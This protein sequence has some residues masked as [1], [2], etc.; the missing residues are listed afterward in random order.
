MPK[1]KENL[2][3]ES[4]KLQHLFG[5]KVKHVLYRAQTKVLDVNIFCSL[6]NKSYNLSD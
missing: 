1:G 3:K 2:R 5:S 4:L 6:P